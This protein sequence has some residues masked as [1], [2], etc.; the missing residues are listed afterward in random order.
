MKSAKSKEHDKN[1]PSYL[2]KNN[3]SLEILSQISLLITLYLFVAAHRKPFYVLR[4]KFYDKGIKLTLLMSMIIHK[5]YRNR[6]K[7]GHSGFTL[8][9]LWC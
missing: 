5:I 7:L 8:L 4:N 3:F 9:E 1:K 2:S 6:F